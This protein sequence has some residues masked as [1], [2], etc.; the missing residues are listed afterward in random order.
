M[1]AK[2]GY[3][4][5]VP[6]SMVP[7]TSEMGTPELVLGLARA[8]NPSHANHTKPPPTATL[9][10]GDKWQYC[11]T[12]GSTGIGSDTSPSRDLGYADSGTEGMLFE[13][14]QTA[15]PW[16]LTGKS[17]LIAPNGIGGYSSSVICACQWF[18]A[19]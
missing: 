14:F 18:S 19:V 2:S 3:S 12:E 4:C 11:C 9:A 13:D 8:T 17:V 5:N 6:P 16:D 15:N 7:P 10:C 1:S